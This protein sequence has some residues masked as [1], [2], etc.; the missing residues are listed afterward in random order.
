MGIRCTGVATAEIPADTASVTLRIDARHPH[1]EDAYELRREAVALA[2]AVLAAVPAVSVREE[3]IDENAWQGE[4]TAGWECRVE[5]AVPCAGLRE[6]IARLADV[7]S[8]AVR[9]PQWR[10]SG[11]A[12]Q[13]VREGLLAEAARRARREAE[14][15]AES[16]GGTLGEVTAVN[17]EAGGGH[18]EPRALAVAGD[19]APLPPRTLE[20][21]MEPEVLSLTEAV[22]VEFAIS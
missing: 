4:Y 10:L 1:P 18:V 21:G 22:T 6:L 17:A 3:R 20:L 19:A 2:R 9:G 16:L 13:R 5:E 15:L 8:V 12:R 14:V 11:A 7:P